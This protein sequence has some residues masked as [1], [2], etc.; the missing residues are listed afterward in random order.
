MPWFLVRCMGIT[1]DGSRA[2]PT[3]SFAYSQG[4]SVEERAAKWGLTKA[5]A[6]AAPSD[7]YFKGSLTNEEM[8]RRN[9]HDE[10][11]YGYSIEPADGPTDGAWIC[12]DFLLCTTPIVIGVR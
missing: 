10:D 5:E 7:L 8:A 2:F 3:G 12:D 6:G 11:T 9:L 4:E 1:Y